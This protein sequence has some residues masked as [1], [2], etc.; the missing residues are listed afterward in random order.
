MHQSSIVGGGRKKDQ[1]RLATGE[2]TRDD[3]GEGEDGVEAFDL[4][5]YDGLG[6]QDEV[7]TTFLQQGFRVLVCLAVGLDNHSLPNLILVNRKESLF[8][9]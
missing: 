3:M 1:S 6:R 2:S 7:R 5:Y 8:A 9:K 4:E